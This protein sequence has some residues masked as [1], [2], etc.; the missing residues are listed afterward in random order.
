MSRGVFQQINS[1]IAIKHDICP[2][3]KAVAR[4]ESIMYTE[5]PAVAGAKED[6][7]R[8]LAEVLP[9]F[10]NMGV[11]NDAAWVIVMPSTEDHGKAKKQ[12]NM[13]RMNLEFAAERYINSNRAD[14]E[15]EDLIKA[16]IGALNNIDPKYA[17]SPL[18]AYA[19]YGDHDRALFCFAGNPHYNPEHPR[20]LPHDAIVVTM[21][22]DVRSAETRYPL[23]MGKMNMAS[24]AGTICPFVSSLDYEG[25]KR[26]FGDSSDVNVSPRDV[27]VIQ[28]LIIEVV[29]AQKPFYLDPITL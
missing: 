3:G 28:R 9:Q 21:N 7:R 26:Y 4:K 6:V 23:V 15:I 2:F 20:Y 18:V 16:R 5:L 10:L 24:V 1:H 11:G 14:D 17:Q 8:R 13:V 19:E 25:L 27:L 29:K 12:A 22:A